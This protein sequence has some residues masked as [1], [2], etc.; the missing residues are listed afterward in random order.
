MAGRSTDIAS[1]YRAY[2]VT[3]GDSTTIETT[4]GLYIGTTGD[5]TVRMAGGMNVTFATVPV[6]VF[7]VQ[8]DR[9]LSTGTT[10]SNIVALY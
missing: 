6:G 9:V 1:A 10:A 5:L 4:R 7:T 2:A 8:V 3:P